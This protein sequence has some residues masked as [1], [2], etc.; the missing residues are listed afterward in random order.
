M[1]IICIDMVK[2]CIFEEGNYYWWEIIY[3]F[4]K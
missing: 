3:M 4:I 1:A 2:M